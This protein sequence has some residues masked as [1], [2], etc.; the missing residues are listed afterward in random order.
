MDKNVKCYV[1][2]MLINRSS[3]VRTLSPNLGTWVVLVLWSVEPNCW[4]VHISYHWKWTTLGSS[5]SRMIWL[6][7]RTSIVHPVNDAPLVS[8]VKYTDMSCIFVLLCMK[9]LPY[10]HEYKKTSVLDS[11]ETI[12]PCTCSEVSKSWILGQ[13]RFSKLWSVTSNWQWK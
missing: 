13:R 3:L 7:R 10:K 8:M 12:H 5:M 9:C 6:I 4:S 2:V 1:T 11:W